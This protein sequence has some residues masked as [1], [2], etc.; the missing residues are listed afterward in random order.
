MFLSSGPIVST[1]S[2]VPSE[3]HVFYASSRSTIVPADLPVVV[4]INRGSA[5]ASEILAGALQDTG[6]ATVIGETSY[7]KGSVQQIKRIDGAGFRL[8][9]SRYYTPAGKNID[10]IG[11]KPNV[12]VLEPE[13]TDAEEKALSQLIEGN[14]IADFVAAHP[15]PSQADISGF[16]QQ[17]SSEG[18]Q[19][20]PRYVERLIRN[21]INRTNNNPPVYDLEYDLVLRRAVDLLRQ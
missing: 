15:N 13:L 18:I 7:G 6:R 1:R 3:N 17:L 20:G 4:L 11:I 21:E 5:S 12:E 8:T 14:R 10:K 16:E 9:M 19:L 2:R